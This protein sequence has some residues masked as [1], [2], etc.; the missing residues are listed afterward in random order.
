MLY[1]IFIFLN[2]INFYG[3]IDSGFYKYL[4]DISKNIDRNFDKSYRE[5]KPLTPI[6]IRFKEEGS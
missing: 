1:F 3:Y 4:W 6:T 2:L 5:A